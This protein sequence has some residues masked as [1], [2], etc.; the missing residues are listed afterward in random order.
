MSTE[1][2]EALQ[3]SLS[4]HIGGLVAISICAGMI[5]ANH[6]AIV[7]NLVHTE[8]DGLPGDLLLVAGMLKS[9]GTIDLSSFQ[10]ALASAATYHTEDPESVEK[11]FDAWLEQM[12]GIFKGVTK[13]MRGAGHET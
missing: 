6:K 9:H 5:E 1:S 4:T 3:Q 2:I 7:D 13:Q 10:T 8:N 12:K 11:C